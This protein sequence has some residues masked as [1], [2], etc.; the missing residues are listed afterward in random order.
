MSFEEERLGPSLSDRPSAARIY[1]YLL[2]GF[3]NFEV[4][5]AIVD[6]M[7]QVQ[8]DLRLGAYANRAFLRRAVRFLVG[9]GIEQ[10]L[11]LG[12]GIPTVGNVHQVAQAINPAVRVV[13]VDVDPI[14]VRHSLSLLEGNPLAT[15]L[16][17]DVRKPDAI[18]SD[19]KVTDLLDF[20][21][22]LGLLAV[23][24]LHYIRDDGEAY[25]AMEL[26]RE[27]L[28]PESY[29]C[30]AHSSS[31]VN[32]AGRE[33][34]RDLFGRASKATSRTYAGI[35]RFFE[36]LDLVEPGLVFTPLWRP[37]GPDELLLEEP[38]RAFTLA[39]VA[40]IG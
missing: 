22:P 3:H 35:A 33:R 39:G 25:G 23:S 7:L 14:A 26:L 11:D 29:V 17:A 40:R 38:W 32:V 28:A 10:F 27:A 13:Y 30:I 20:E 18:V 24:V 12:S 34:L 6:R 16:M 4:D 8:P 9:Q 31:D 21:R 15:A 1:D 5:R 19:P 36:G 2:G 37:E